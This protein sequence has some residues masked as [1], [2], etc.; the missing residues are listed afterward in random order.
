MGS[1][2][3]RCRIVRPSRDDRGMAN[4][5]R[6]RLLVVSAIPVAVIVGGV[7]GWAATRTGF[8]FD[9]IVATA[10]ATAAGTVALA[11]VTGLLAVM[12]AREVQATSAIETERV[13]PVLV[14]DGIDRFMGWNT[15]PD[16]R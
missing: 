14:I 12:T 7:V 15:S 2:L 9:W 5:A 3:P 13:R 6:W 4:R 8:S 1:V 16:I 11:V 10:A